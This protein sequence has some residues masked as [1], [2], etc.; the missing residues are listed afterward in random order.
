MALASGE[1]GVE[2]HVGLGRQRIPRLGRMVVM[3]AVYPDLYSEETAPW[4]V[5]FCDSAN[6]A[7]YGTK[8]YVRKAP[9]DPDSFQIVAER[10]CMVNDGGLYRIADEFDLLETEYLMAQ[11]QL[12]QRKPEDPQ[13]SM[14]FL[15][16][17]YTEPVAENC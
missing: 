9:G 12:E 17:M 1:G 4:A 10:A 7:L 11:E 15:E 5:C 2:I 14:S 16:G 3:Q 13:L 8:F 6:E